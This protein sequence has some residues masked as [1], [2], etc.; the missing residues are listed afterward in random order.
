MR[1]LASLLSLT[2]LFFPLSTVP[3][4]AQADEAAW[5]LAQINALR[6]RNGQVLLA[7]N[8]HLI[9]SAAA[10]S[11]YLATHPYS[12]P[13]READGSTPQSRALA[14]GYPGRLV[15]ENVVGGTGSN[16][17]WAFDWWMK[18]PIHLHNMLAGWTEIGIGIVVGP[19]GRW[20]TTD[21][22]DQGAGLV[23]PTN[24]PPSPGATIAGDTPNSNPAPKADVPRPTRRPTIAPTLTPTITLTPSITFT[25]QPT[26]TP[27][28]TPTGLP[29]T[30][31]PIV[32][33]VSPPPT[34]GPP[35][36][37]SP[38]GAG[39]AATPVTPSPVAVAMLGAANVSSAP[40]QPAAQPSGDPLR[41]L[42]PWLLAL[43][44][45]VFGGLLIGSL[46]RRRHRL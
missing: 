13:H 43:Q 3:A 1:T 40:V 2:L 46:I 41:G 37:G 34:N 26:I 35:I 33:E 18:S 20:Y 5:L 16:V 30:V 14:A 11:T 25:P 15:G 10:H 36:N 29:P 28:D 32:L 17:Q 4:R 7:L 6:Q 21:F 27:T 12:D 42:I 45:V 9:A 39:P 44:G 38:A 24:P 8:P 19:Y 22:G 31:T 23:A